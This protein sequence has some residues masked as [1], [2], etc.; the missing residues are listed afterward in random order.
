MAAHLKN[1]WQWD[2]WGF[3]EDWAHK[4]TMSDIDGFVPFLGERGGHFLIVEMKHWDGRGNRPHINR[5][6]G[7]FIALQR[8]A[9]QPNFTVVVGLGNTATRT[10]HYYEVWN[11]EGQWT[12]DMGFKQY[13]EHWFRRASISAGLPP[14]RLSSLQRAM[15]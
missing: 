13:L 10:I 12:M 1:T 2:A 11:E 14:D 4:C 6:S 8:L 7:Q 9:Q 3:T 5:G 15:Q